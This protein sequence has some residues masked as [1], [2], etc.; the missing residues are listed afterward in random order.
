MGFN[1]EKQC[2]LVTDTQYVRK[3][4]GECDTNQVTE[5]R[6]YITEVMNVQIPSLIPIVLKEAVIIKM[7]IHILPLLVIGWINC[8]FLRKLS[9]HR[10]C[11]LVIVFNYSS[12]RN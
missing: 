11:I 10:R 3:Q 1:K 4:N 12:C 7:L 8:Q 5:F 6:Q 9:K 2:S